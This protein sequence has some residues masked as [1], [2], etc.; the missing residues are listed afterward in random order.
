MSNSIHPFQIGEIV[1]QI[2][3][4]L[5]LND[6][7]TCLRLSSAYLPVWL[8]ILY[9]DI[10]VMDFD[11]HITEDVGQE[12]AKRIPS[13]ASDGQ[14]L[15]CGGKYVHKYSH[16][17]K[18]VTLVD[19]HSLQYLGDNCVNLT[20]IDMILRPLPKDFFRHPVD[21]VNKGLWRKWDTY[22]EKTAMDETVL[23]TWLKLFE[24]NPGL[25]SVKMG[26]AGF[27]S[28]SE[29]IVRAL[30]RL[31]QLRK[32]FMMQI[33]E[34]NTTE[35]ILDCCPHLHTLYLGTSYVQPRSCHQEFRE[36]TEAGAP[37]YPTQI[38]HLSFVDG[39]ALHIRGWAKHV[40]AR[41]PELKHLALPYIW[42]KLFPEVAIV[43]P[44]YCP[45]LE[46]LEVAL[47]AYGSERIQDEEALD[48][49]LKGCPDLHSLD[50]FEEERVFSAQR[51]I[52]ET[53]FATRLQS[54]SYSG[55]ALHLQTEDVIEVMALCPNLTTVDIINTGVDI[56]DFLALRFVCQGSLRFLRVRLCLPDT[57]VVNSDDEVNSS[58]DM[59]VIQT[60]LLK[61]LGQLECLEELF[62]STGYFG[63]RRRGQTLPLEMVHR[64]TF[65]KL[66]ILKRLL[67]LTIND[68]TPVDKRRWC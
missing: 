31:K 36:E 21:Y 32:L 1:A 41:C 39:E 17:I 53:G 22:P 10:R 26:L 63:P 42:R 4:Y 34:R 46:R 37:P 8:S 67:S 57:A 40:L 23:K 3:T 62:L 29:Q 28:Q 48:L 7:T 60:R 55:R 52:K 14:N 58:D 20:N 6:L 11:Y 45:K 47:R 56:E 30:G 33:S 61:R 59:E 5:S 15:G 64:Y 35:L 27:G 25:V 43:I 24:G 51:Q 16:W 12:L 13:S 18:T 68:D 2:A 49:V 19:R 9:R 50:V 66:G 38:K 65:V 44:Q 54:F